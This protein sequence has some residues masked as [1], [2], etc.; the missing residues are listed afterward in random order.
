MIAHLLII[1]RKQAVLGQKYA[2]EHFTYEMI[3]RQMTAALW[4][5]VLSK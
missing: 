5:V 1:I 2:S 3:G 4:K